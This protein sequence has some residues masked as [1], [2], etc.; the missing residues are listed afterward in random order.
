MRGTP[1]IAADVGAGVLVKRG[2]GVGIV[3]RRLLVVDDV[4]V[5]HLELVRK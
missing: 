4:L 3:A 1:G 5:R 2:D